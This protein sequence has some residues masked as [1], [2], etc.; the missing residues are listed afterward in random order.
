M[1]QLQNPMEQE[2]ERLRKYS[3]TDAAAENSEV[4][5]DHHEFRCSEAQFEESLSHVHFP[6]VQ[7]VSIV[8]VRKTKRLLKPTTF[9][10]SFTSPH[11]SVHP[12]QLTSPG[13]HPPGPF[14]GAGRWQP[15]RRPGR[16]RPWHW[17]RQSTVARRFERKRWQHLHPPGQVGWIQRLRTLVVQCGI[18]A[19]SKWRIEFL[20]QSTSRI[21]SFWNRYCREEFVATAHP[22]GSIVC[23]HL[24]SP[25]LDSCFKIQIIRTKVLILWCHLRV[26]GDEPIGEVRINCTT[27]PK[28]DQPFVDHPTLTSLYPKTVK[29]MIASR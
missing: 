21:L 9:P 29:K 27:N 18:P 20:K 23:V 12:M 19:L 25:R 3:T 7:T 13:C 5:C 24:V 16:P 4:F 8:H 2:Y 26:F 10:T 15:P 17:H 6:K 28:H 1:L 11:A 14:V 22:I